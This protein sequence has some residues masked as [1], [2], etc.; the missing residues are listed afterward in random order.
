MGDLSPFLGWSFLNFSHQ[1]LTFYSCLG[2]YFL[3]SWYIKLFQL[4]M[5]YG[6]CEISLLC[7]YFNSAPSSVP[8]L[9]YRTAE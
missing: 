1:K 9:A 5:S 8:F 6:F 2:M 3:F 7:R 4:L